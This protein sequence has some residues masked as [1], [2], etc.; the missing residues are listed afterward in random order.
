M[1]TLYHYNIITFYLTYPPN[2]LY[3]PSYYI[4]FKKCSCKQFFKLTIYSLARFF[5]GIGVLSFY[6]IVHSITQIYIYKYTH[7]YFFI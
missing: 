6:L 7:V 4:L 3:Y 5:N 2:C 1:I